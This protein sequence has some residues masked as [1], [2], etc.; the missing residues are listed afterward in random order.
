VSDNQP[1]NAPTF[2]PLPRYGVIALDG[3]EAAVFAQAQF[4]NDVS[5]LAPGH[6]HWNTWLTAKGRVIAVFALLKQAD[7]ALLL[8]LPDM[9]AT[10]FCDT[11]RRFV[12]RRKVSISPADWRVAGAFATPACARDNALDLAEARIELDL[13]A[14]DGPRTLRLHREA[15]DPPSADFALRWYQQDL[16]VGLPR[17]VEGQRE[18]WTPQQLSLERLHAFS[19]R[20]GCYPGQE[21]V[22][23]TH[24]LGKT[25]RGALLLESAQPLPA[26][27]QVL[28][29]GQAVGHVAC[30]TEAGTLALAVLPLDLDAAQP[31]QVQPDPAAAAVPVHVR[32]LVDGLAR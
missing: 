8:V 32:P 4:A 17:L 13:G 29:S 11:L 10:A 7:D 21:I 23:R 25:K 15:I 27:A 28:Q 18:Q 16:R 2:A 22:A 3:P 26:G 9:P 30:G 31:L 5:A 24:F 6:W 19:V 12:F 20:K 1:A 14:A